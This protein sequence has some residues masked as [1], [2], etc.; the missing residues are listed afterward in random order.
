MSAIP[1]N[2]LEQV[3]FHQVAFVVQ[4]IDKAVK[5]WADVLHIGPW[6]VYTLNQPSLKDCFHRGQATEF[7]IRH[8]LTWS[9]NI[10]F[11][12]I[13]PLHGPSIYQEQLDSRGEGF[14]HIGAIVE[15]HAVAVA[16]MIAHGF[17]KIQSA[18]GFG[19]EGDGSFAF[20]SLPNED[21][22]IIELVA[23]P[24]VR[25]APDYTYPAIEGV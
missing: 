22:V 14:N 11:E 18:N 2:V 24:K 8:A 25:K 7:G 1:E 5:Y 3:K 15:D 6:S 9:G 17:T 23:P 20:F 13:Q 4:D 10:Q 21:S 16:S 19:A 12:L